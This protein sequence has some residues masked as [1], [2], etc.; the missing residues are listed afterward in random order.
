MD[1]PLEAI[2]VTVTPGNTW[3]S[4]PIPSF[5]ISE[6]FVRVELEDT[7]A[8]IQLIEATSLDPEGWNTY[9]VAIPITTV[10]GTLLPPN[11]VA[12]AVVPIGSSIFALEIGY[13]GTSSIFFFNASIRV[14]KFSGQGV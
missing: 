2:D 14:S 11:N 8:D 12:S 4:P 9:A 10:S 6:V 5:G 7:S 3:T 1:V 13:F